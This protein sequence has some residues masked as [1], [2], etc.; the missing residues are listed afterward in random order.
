L[1]TFDRQTLELIDRAQ[2]VDIETVR[3][4]GMFRRTTIWPIVDRGEVFVRSLR[5]DRGYWYQSARENPDAVSLMVGNRSIPVRVIAATDS[6]SVNRC[7]R[8]YQEKY[9]DDPATPQMV[10]SSTLGSTLRLEPR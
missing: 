8:G 4:D 7:S 10:R 1:K 5:G 2:E 9:A 6:E 3:P